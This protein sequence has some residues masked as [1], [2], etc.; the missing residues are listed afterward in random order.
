MGQ[1]AVRVALQ[2]SESDAHLILN[3]E[4]TAARLLSRPGEA[5]YNDANGVIEGN[6]F[7]Q[8]VWLSDSRRDD[9]LDA[10]N[11]L[12]Q[13]TPRSSVRP[14]IVFEGQVAAELAE[15]H[16]LKSLIDQTPPQEAPAPRSPGSATPWRSRTRPPRSSAA[17][18]ARTCW[19]SARTPRRAIGLFLGAVASLGA[20]HP[21]ED[22]GESAAATA[23]LVF[24]DGTPDDAPFA[25]LPARLLA[26]VP[27]TDVLDWREAGRVVAEVASVVKSRQEDA[28]YEAPPI[29][30]F[31][32]NLSRFRD[33]RKADD[34]FSFSRKE[35]SASPSQQFADIL[36]EGPAYG[37]HVIAWCDGWNNLQRMLDRQSLREFEL[38]ILFQMSPND[39]SNLI[40]SPAAGKLGPHRAFYANE[41][42]G[43]LEK[44][45]PYGV[46]PEAWWDHF[47]E[48]LKNPTSIG[49]ASEG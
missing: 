4:N 7:F 39:S 26:D 48:R 43:I 11:E 20:Q 1:M 16:L 32:Y 49:A 34:D 22:R 47:R 5:I 8:V 36:K 42:E 25:G 44:F 15:N 10:I 23:R 38:R 3:E 17:S 21:V 19:W 18:R 40:D 24:L 27:G 28:R 46:A 33:L 14:Q 45:R 9:Y 13:A 12:D 2:C 30:L 31:V 35:E 41:E 37:V 29:F 6:N